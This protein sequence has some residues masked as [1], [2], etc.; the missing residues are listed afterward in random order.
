MGG[1]KARVEVQQQ[2]LARR[3][4]F[5]TRGHMARCVAVAQ[6]GHVFPGQ[7]VTAGG[8]QVGTQLVQRGQGGVGGFAEGVFPGHGGLTVDQVR[9]GVVGQPAVGG[10]PFAQDVGHFLVRAVG[11]ALVDVG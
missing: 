2:R 11:L 6:I 3:A 1:V 7:V 10:H 5:G 8:E 4:R 9:A